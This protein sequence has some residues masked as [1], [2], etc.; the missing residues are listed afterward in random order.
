MDFCFGLGTHT[1]TN[2]SSVLHTQNGPISLCTSEDEF[3][4]LFPM[5]KTGSM[6]PLS[7]EHD[8]PRVGPAGSDVSLGS[9]LVH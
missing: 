6:E 7:Q 2:K 3:A 1:A 4:T 8:V 9:S 5:A